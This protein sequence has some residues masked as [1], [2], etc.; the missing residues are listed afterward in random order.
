M[1]KQILFLVILALITS[2]SYFIYINAREV[3]SYVPGR[4]PEADTA[5]NQAKHLYTITKVS[6]A[7]FSDGPCLT[8]A[9]LP[10]WVAD[11]VHSPRTPEDDLPKNQCSAFI[12]GTATHFVELDTEGNLIRVK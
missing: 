6:G 10:G 12:N 2:F 5:I 8:D 11:I 1:S 7:D 3:P 4:W 9:L